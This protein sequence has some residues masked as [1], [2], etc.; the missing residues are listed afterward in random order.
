MSDATAELS[1]AEVNALLAKQRQQ[2]QP[3]VGDGGADAGAFSFG[4]P[5]PS[6]A[7]QGGEFARLFKEVNAFQPVRGGEAPGSSSSRPGNATDAMFG[8]RLGSSAL[9]GGAA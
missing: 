5:T 8:E 2:K 6:S 4:G 3:P 1:A 9:G 7:Q